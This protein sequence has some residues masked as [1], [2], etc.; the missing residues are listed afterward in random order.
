MSDH[1]ELI[2][3]AIAIIGA[4]HLSEKDKELLLGRIPYVPL[5]VLQMFVQICEDDPFSIDPII[6]NLK[7]KID[8]S[9]NLQKI[10]ALVEQERK[11]IALSIK[12]K[13]LVRDSLQTQSA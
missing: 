6:V 1:K 11:D 10:H 7:K 5:S 13:E 3:R 8:A 2:E 9:G 4:A 12:D